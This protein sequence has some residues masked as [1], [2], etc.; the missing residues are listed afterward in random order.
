MLS[1][2]FGGDR[3]I[4]VTSDA[5]P[6]TARTFASYGAIANEAGLSRIYAGQHT[7]LDDMAGRVLGA[8]VADFLLYSS[9]S[10]GFGSRAVPA[11]RTSGY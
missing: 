2:F 3:Q 4:G 9:N 7:P 1:A 5:L 8:Q 11:Y 10:A 6:G